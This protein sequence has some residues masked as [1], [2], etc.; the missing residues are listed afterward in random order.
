MYVFDFP[1]R[2][3][4][5]GGKRSSSLIR[6]FSCSKILNL[7]VDFFCLSWCFFIQFPSEYAVA[8]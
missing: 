7:F 2:G 4:F 5:G 6:F 3:K 8:S 1:R